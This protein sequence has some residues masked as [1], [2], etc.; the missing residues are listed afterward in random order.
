M[1]LSKLALYG[2]IAG[3][4][5]AVSA[6]STVQ[7]SKQFNKTPI[8][9]ETEEEDEEE[10]LY[11][12]QMSD[13]EKFI[14]ELTAFGN[15]EGNLNVS[16]SKGAYTATIKGDV[17]VSMESLEDV[18]VDAK[19]V[20][21]INNRD[22]NIDA[23]Y[24]NNTIY[25]TLEGNNI[26]METSSIND[27]TSMISSMN[28]SVKLPST[29]DNID[30]DKLLV[31]LGSMTAEK[32]DNSITYTCNLLE[33]FPPII[34][35]SDLEYKMTSLKVSNFEI[36]GFKI[37]AYATTN[38]LGK[39][40]NRIVVPE[41]A[42]NP[43]IN[44]SNTITNT[45]DGLVN[46]INNL[47]NKKEI[48]ISNYNID[49]YKGGNTLDK[50]VFSMNGEANISL[51]NVKDISSCQV[52]LSGNML[53]PNQGK[54]LNSNVDIK[55][56][57]GSVY[58]DYNNE[59]KLKYSVD[60]IKGLIEI[61]KSKITNNTTTD[62]AS[63]LD[64]V[65][66]TSNDTKSSPIVDIIKNKNYLDILDYYL[67]TTIDGER[68]TTSVVFDGA[69]IGNNDAEI[70]LSF[71]T[72]SKGITN[73]SINGLYALGYTLDCSFD[74]DTYKSFT[75][76]EDDMNSYTNL[77]YINN[78]FDQVF[79]L[80]HKDQFALS[81]K[82]KV[83][84]GKGELSIKGSSYVSLNED[85][86]FGVADLVIN[87]DHHIKIDVNRNK[88]N[89]DASEEEKKQ[90]LETSEILFSYNDNLNGYLNLNSVKET[91]DLIKKLASDGNPLLER[92]QALM[93]KD[94]TQSTI[95]KILEGE[96]EAILYDNSL[97]AITYRDD[98]NG[99]Y[100]DIQ[101]N[102]NFLKSNE[103]DDNEPTLHLYINLDNDNNFTGLGIEVSLNSSY[104]FDIDLGISEAN[105]NTIS[106]NR[107][108]KNNSDSPYYDFSELKTLT[109]YLFNTATNKNFHIEGTVNVSL[110]SPF[111]IIVDINVSDEGETVAKVQF[112]D[113]PYFIGL[114]SISRNSTIYVVEKKVNG[115]MNRDIY[116]ET[117]HKD[118]LITS[119]KTDRVK[120]TTEEF[121]N[122]IVYYLVN[123]TLG[124]TIDVSSASSSSNNKIDYS[125]ILKGFNYST[126][127]NIPTW[128]LTLDVGKLAGT[129]ALNDA[130]VKISGTDINGSRYLNHLT[131]NLGII[132]ILSA[133]IDATVT[134]F[135]YNAVKTGYESAISYS[136]AHASDSY[137]YK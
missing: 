102:G 16:V 91:I 12:R 47:L 94:T 96:P 104:S 76:S 48:G 40:H 79:A 72:G 120:L 1:F 128:D 107:L 127:N 22:F 93:N 74:L 136:N 105:E 63:V 26:K 34:F 56:Y 133:D 44:L 126:K 27:I 35:T 7:I 113:I 87:D 17:F 125:S 73:I 10:E 29:F 116:I 58:F 97:E 8:P 54:E 25:A 68:H 89:K 13:T 20:F 39:G 31:N 81:L 124:L 66:P 129:S 112:K 78:I 117:T 98:I 84:L 52:S 103:N 32:D 64:K 137:N 85:N 5:F 115:E 67:R 118:H 108:D 18:Q 119:K 14:N 95:N 109:E 62:V 30:A 70:A 99:H 4:F 100:Y 131:A 60:D 3:T 28:A 11:V 42:N 21:N 37:D 61:I 53:N 77:G 90:A 83:N 132:G 134:S 106:W 71:K 46:Q 55:L 88:V 36:E 135:E 19:L 41:N 24:L 75:M 80:V 23:T 50:L 49:V 86:D 38:I 111:D 51:P 15:M 69:L 33:G 114:T 45:K 6:F 122:N 110:L 123:Y 65:F 9:N 2:T 101:I 121:T 57:E 43:Y 130:N 59:L 82:G 92:I